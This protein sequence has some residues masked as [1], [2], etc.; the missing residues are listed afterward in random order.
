LRQP[1][2]NGTSNEVSTS[3]RRSKKFRIPESEDKEQTNVLHVD[4]QTPDGK[5][6]DNLWT[7][8]NKIDSD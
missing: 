4:G 1:A 7:N 2:H 5:A 8:Y 3:D 6:K